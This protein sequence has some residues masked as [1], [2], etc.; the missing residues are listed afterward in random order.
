[1]KGGFLSKAEINLQGIL[2]QPN[3]QKESGTALH[4]STESM[5]LGILAIMQSRLHL[6]FAWRF[7]LEKRLPIAFSV[8]PMA[9]Q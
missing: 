9:G 4:V 8:T 1:M 3:P 6:L 5:L 2:Y 7:L